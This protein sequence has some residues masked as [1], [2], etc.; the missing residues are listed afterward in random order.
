MF[1]LASDFLT[2][3]VTNFGATIK[4]IV[5]DDFQGMSTDVVLGFDSLAEYEVNAPYL[6]VTVGRCCN[7]IA[8]GKFELDGVLH[9]LPINNGENSLHGGTVGFS[10]KVWRA[11]IISDEAVKMTY[12]SPDGEE[13]YPGTLTT[14]VTFTLIHDRL[15]L[16]YHATTNKA[17]VINLTN[18]SYFNLNGGGSIYGQLL[19]I[20]CDTFTPI[21]ELSIP[22]GEEL[23]VADTVFDFTQMK[24]MGTDIESTDQQLTFAKGY[25]HGFCHDGDYSKIAATAFSKDTGISLNLFTTQPIV[26]LYTGNYLGG[27]I[28]KSGIAYPDYSGFCLETQ[29]HTD[30]INQPQFPT[31]VL[32]PN[33]TFES[34]TMFKISI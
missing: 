22:T 18:H 1:T 10:H 34:K 2:V 25:D 19:E 16:T 4:S 13:G 30:A 3:E 21:S 15:E 5:L 26:H 7:R 31:T 8:K 24:T 11:E 9:Q 12:V 28:G 6:G 27:Q 17:T 14:S 23:P 29:H 32:R 33:Q 20:N